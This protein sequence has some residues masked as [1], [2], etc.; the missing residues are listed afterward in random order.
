[1]H[2]SKGALLAFLGAAL[3][4]PASI[5]ERGSGKGAPPCRFA[6]QWTTSDVLE[7][8]DQFIWDMLYWE[9]KFHEDGVAFD[10]EHGLSLDGSQID[11]VTGEKTK[12]HAFSA[13]SKEVSSVHLD[14]YK[15]NIR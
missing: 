3:A 4:Q 12:K 11:W 6:L 10:G 13:A 2:F 9:G 15:I 7:K 1:M 5:A 8:T 14:I